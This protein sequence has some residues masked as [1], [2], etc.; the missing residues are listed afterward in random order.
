[1]YG[2]ASHY[3]EPPIYILYI[4]IREQRSAASSGTQSLRFLFFSKNFQAGTYLA[5]SFTK[6][7]TGCAA[8]EAPA[9]DVSERKRATHTSTPTPLELAGAWGQ[10]RCTPGSVS[11]PT[12]MKHRETNQYYKHRRSIS[13][14]IPGLRIGYMLRLE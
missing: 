8:S 12:S 14:T 11:G 10:R 13:V 6:D 9:Y 5:L 4:Y 1:M 7:T 3:Y 2:M